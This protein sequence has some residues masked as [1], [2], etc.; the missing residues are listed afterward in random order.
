MR[1]MRP[2]SDAF[3]RGVANGSA[4]RTQIPNV[5]MIDTGTHACIRNPE[6]IARGCANHTG[7]GKIAG[8]TMSR[9]FAEKRAVIRA[10]CP[11]LAE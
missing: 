4:I 9:Q 2:C 1:K 7:Y 6:G 10:L 11:M 8:T 3:A 5:A